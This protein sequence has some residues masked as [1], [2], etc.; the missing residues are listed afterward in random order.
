MTGGRSF[1]STGAVAASVLLLFGIGHRLA[2]A[3]LTTITASV[4]LPRGTLD[5]LPMRLGDWNGHDV[6]LDERVIRATDTDDHVHREYVRNGESVTL[7]VAYGVRMR[8]LFPHRPEVCYP[9][10]GWTLERARDVTVPDG[11][12]TLSAR[13]LRFRKGGLDGQ[14]LAVLN[15]Y[16]VDGQA[17]PDVSLLRSRVWRRSQASYAAQVQIASSIGVSEDHR[18]EMLRDVAEAAAPVIATLIHRAVAGALSTA[19]SRGE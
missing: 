14:S 1:L 11:H 16:L 7:Y 8:D 2:T 6:P 5:A 4:P 15:Y 10:A 3:R 19:D 9:S 17:C 18:E 12:E 13:V